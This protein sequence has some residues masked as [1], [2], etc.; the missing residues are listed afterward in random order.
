[1]TTAT[2]N[3]ARVVAFALT[4]ALATTALSGCIGKVAPGSA[5]SMAKAEKAI[6]KGKGPKAVAYAEAAV[7]ADP[8]NAEMRSLLAKA[9]IEAGRFGSAAT[10]FE[11]A[12]QLGDVSGRTVLMQALT[13]SA[14]GRLTEA[15][16]LLDRYERNLD[17]ADFGL[18]ITVAGRPQQGIQVLS[19]VLRSGIN[20]MQVRQ[21]LAYAFALNGDW[22]SA[23]LVAQQD[24][25]AD[26][27]AQRMGQWAVLAQPQMAAERVAALL[28]TNVAPDSGQPAELALANFPSETQLAL[29]AVA[30]AETAPTSLVEAADTELPAVASADATD[31]AASFNME[32]TAPSD[33]PASAPVAVSRV[34]A[35]PRIVLPKPVPALVAD[36]PASSK[37]V[38]VAKAQP[39]RP[40][41]AFAAAFTPGNYTIQLGSFA[42][43]AI[44]DEAWSRFLK[45]YPELKGATKSV[46]KAKVDGKIYYRVAAAGFAKSSANEVCGVVKKRGGGCFA[47]AS[48]RTLPGTVSDATRVAT[49]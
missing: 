44:A 47:Y 41:K 39:T 45:R 37:P 42:S 48:A 29:A 26:V 11:E 18:A 36:E 14:A 38:S 31:F 28:N 17:P 7:L 12:M 6:A 25:S 24:L 8:R 3:K 13:L 1:M 16:T 34:A 40:S 22:R 9:Y 21:N 32:E 23:R 15:Q 19:N 10:A 5:S 35:A 2:A 49:R 20:T 27:L 46:T 43:G 4:T 30:E 33:T